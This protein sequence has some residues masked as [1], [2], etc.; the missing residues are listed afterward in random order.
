MPVVPSVILQ[1][2]SQSSFLLPAAVGVALALALLAGIIGFRRSR[3]RSYSSAPTPPPP[4]QPVADEEDT[5]PLA[6][7]GTPVARAASAPSPVR[8]AVRTDPGRVREMNED[9]TVSAGLPDESGQVRTGLYAV[10]DGIGGHDDGEVAS[11]TAIEATMAALEDEPL[12]HR[13]E[14]ARQ[15][16]GDDE[17]LE[18]LR[19][20]VL[21]ANRAVYGKKVDLRSNMGTTLVLALVMRGRAYVANV[22]DSRAYLIR[23]GAMKQLT[24]DHSLVERMLA[25]GQITEAEARRHPQRNLV[26]R[27]LGSGTDV[28]VDLFVERLQ[29]G[30][31][32]LL[33]SD[34]LSDMLPDETLGHLASDERDLD[35]ACRR[36]IEAAN[37]AGGRD[38]ISVVIA[39][40]LP[41]EPANGVA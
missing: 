10:A 32:L 4:R 25:S 34:G 14:T 15:A 20:A 35:R 16:A 2:A 24:E 1:T 9:A 28:E 12:F 22:G 39:E 37:E 11:R 23:D 33:C 5:Q 21:S 8:A 19:T 7:P 36:L 31:R 27:S 18:A 13:P 38:N 41:S 29:P 17:V 40:V 6:M 26:F 30:D 3:T